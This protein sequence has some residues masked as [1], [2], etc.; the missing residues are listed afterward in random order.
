MTWGEWGLRK[1]A[2]TGR[3]VRRILPGLLA[4]AVGVRGFVLPEDLVRLGLCR[5]Q[6]IRIVEEVLCRRQR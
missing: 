5:V 1:Q 4:D 3:S 2:S 6:D